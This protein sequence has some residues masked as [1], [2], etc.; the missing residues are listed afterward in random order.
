MPENIEIRAPAAGFILARNVSLGQRFEKGTE[1]YRIADLAQV[2]IVADI[3]ETEA[4]AFKPGM[5]VRVSAPATGEE[6]LCAA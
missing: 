1:L 2:W 4:T 5:P 6:L 3:F